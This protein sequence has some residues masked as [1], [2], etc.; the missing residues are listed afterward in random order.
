MKKTV[1]LSLYLAI[2]ANLTVLDAQV[3]VAV[4]RAQS[5]TPL[6]GMTLFCDKNYNCGLA[7]AKPSKVSLGDKDLLLKVSRA[8]NDF[9]L[10]IDKNQN[11]SLADDGR[12][13]LRNSASVSVAIRKRV[14]ARRYEF[15]PFEIVHEAPDEQGAAVDHFVLR[16]RYV[17]SGT[18]TYAKCTSR[19]SLVDMN[20]DGRFTAADSDRGTNLRIDKNNDGKFWGKDEHIKTAEIVAFCGQNFLVTSLSNRSMVLA[21]TNLRLAKVSEPVPDFSIALLNGQVISPVS[22]KGKHYV[23]DFWASWCVPCVKNLP[24]IKSVKKEYGS[25]SVFSVNVDRV[26]RRG[27]AQKIIDDTGVKEFTA[28]RGLGDNDPLWKTFGGA[29]LNRLAIPLYVLID[30]EAVVRYA[31]DGGEELTELKREISKLL[32]SSRFEGEEH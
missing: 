21:P 16:P 9:Y 13:F 22:L 26:S 20:F 14:A 27:M 23:L 17:A 28:I 12:V 32:S 18:L 6:P 7:A 5:S 11:G 19:L 31:G 10:I 29:N 30:N 8:G 4:R 15:L 3:T 1:F 25:L 2:A 24:Q